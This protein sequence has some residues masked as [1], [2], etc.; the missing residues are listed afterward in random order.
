MLMRLTH[1]IYLI[2]LIYFRRAF[3][4]GNGE[5][6]NGNGNGEMGN[7]KWEQGAEIWDSNESR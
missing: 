1:S 3:G 5:M 7:G 6:G 4:N 2:H